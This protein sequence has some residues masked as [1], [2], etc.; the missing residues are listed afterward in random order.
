MSGN[1]PNVGRETDTQVQEA[2]KTPSTLNPNRTM[3]TYYNCQIPKIIITLSTVKD[4]ILKAPREKINCTQGNP[5]K[6]S[7]IYPIETF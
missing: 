2:Q 7:G 3:L 1:S 5:H 6:T 4:N